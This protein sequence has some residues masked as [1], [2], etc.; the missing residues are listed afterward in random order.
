MT[1]KKHRLL[2]LTSGGDSPGMNA[3]IRAVV[4]TCYFCSVPVFACHNGY[5]GLVDQDL[6]TMGPAS[7]TGIIQRGGTILRTSRCLAFH[8]YK[9][10][11]KCRDFLAKKG[12]DLLV[13]IGGDGTFR[14]ATLLEEEGGPKSIG[15]PASIDNDVVGTDY[16]LGFD[17]ARNT[18]LDAIDKIRDT[19]TSHSRYFLVEV[20]GRNAGFLAADVA[21][22]GGAEYVITPE[23][24]I[25]IK[26]LAASINAPRRKKQS[27]IIVVAEAN[28]PGRSLKIADQLRKL[29]P[30]EYRVCILGH[31]QRGGSPTVM[32]RLAGSFMGNMAVQSL[33]AGKSNRMTSLKNGQYTL[34]KFS[35]PNLPSRRLE[36]QNI[37]KLDSIL[38][39]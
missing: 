30:F 13:A 16:T 18:A 14:G 3:A 25:S 22:A 21:I 32:D 38:A 34:E 37:I 26:S 2:L 24:P 19:A 8:E 7:V 39:V 31:T 36:D 5:Q 33:L 11:K 12:I 4:R 17:T 1:T 20:M 23:F 6:F 9:T 29:T 35:D 10:R 27:L 15:I 28:Q